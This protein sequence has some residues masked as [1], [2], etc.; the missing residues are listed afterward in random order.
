VAD[1][2]LSR[3]AGAKFGA[4]QGGDGA[5]GEL[6]IRYDK[7]PH[8]AAVVLGRDQNFVPPPKEKNW[9]RS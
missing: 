7:I 4:R 1:W 5:G 3:I 2:T 9:V 6:A 8:V